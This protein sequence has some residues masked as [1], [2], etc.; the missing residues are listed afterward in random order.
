M[1]Q[2]HYLLAA[3]SLFWLALAV[4]FAGVSLSMSVDSQ[5]ALVATMVLTMII[6]VSTYLLAMKGMDRF[7]RYGVRSTERR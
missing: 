6:V 2:S 3:G 5:G 4:L 7:G 1:T